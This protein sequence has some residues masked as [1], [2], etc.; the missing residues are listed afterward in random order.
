MAY[1]IEDAKIDAVDRKIDNKVELFQEGMFTPDEKKSVLDTMKLIDDRWAKDETGNKHITFTRDEHE[2][3][4][5]AQGFPNRFAGV[6][7][8][9]LERAHTVAEPPGE[10]PGHWV[11]APSAVQ[12]GG[13]FHLAY[14]LRRPVGAGRGGAIVVARSDDGVNFETVAVIEKDALGAGSL[15]RPALVVLPDG[16]WRIYMSCATPGTKHWWIGAI[17]ADDPS[18]FDAARHVMVLPGDDTM[19]MK[20][21]VVLRVE[22]RWHMW[23]CCHPLDDAEATDRMVTRY[24]TSRDGLDW[25]IREVALSGRPG[26]WD[27]RGARIT[28][29]LLHAARPVAYYDGRATAGENW[30]ERTGIALAT[31]E[32]SF[33]AVGDRPWAMSPEG[34]GALRYLSVVPLDD[35][36]HRLYYEV[37]RADGAHDLRTE[38]VASR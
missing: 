11:G 5:R 1:G 6:P 24:A 2:A 36:G 23:V 12:V 35:G 32:G 14:R 7:F 20:D 15:E 19:G 34:G 25:T 27:E 17:D 30:K 31:G 37:S 29:V 16:K 10:G 26:A 28:S 3:L 22:D 38:Y 4:S 8:I 13:T 9:D 33:A 18:S 21:P